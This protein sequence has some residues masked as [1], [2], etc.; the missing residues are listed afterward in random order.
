MYDNVDDAR[1]YLSGTVV[2]LDGTPVY[3]RQVEPLDSG[4]I[5]A[6]YRV[7]G[8]DNNRNRTLADGGWDLTPVPL[9][10]I[11]LGRDGCYYLIRTPG[12]RYHQGLHGD[13]LC[14]LRN[15][16]VTVFGFPDMALLSRTILGEYPTYQEVYDAVT[17]GS[18]PKAFTRTLALNG[19]GHITLEHRGTE[20]GYEADSAMVLYPEFA[21]LKE[22]I[23]EQLNGVEVK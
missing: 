4:G 12:R 10:Y 6:R 17:H 15:G 1:M 8:E 22:N 11:N 5:T 2:R 21:Y 18:Q 16:R 23:R 7:L 19:G 20:V 9:G 14:S 3:I 13:S